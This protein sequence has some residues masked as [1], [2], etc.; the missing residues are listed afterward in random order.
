MAPMR[1][2][3]D[4]LRAHLHGQSIGKEHMVACLADGLGLALSW[5]QDDAAH[6]RGIAAHV[7]DL[8]EG[9]PELDLGAEALEEGMGIAEAEV[10]EA[11]VPPADVLLDE[12]QG[13]S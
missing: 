4:H 9:E 3:G 1:A 12:V 6:V 13:I 5:L 10:G 8:I 2:S 11:T 7:V